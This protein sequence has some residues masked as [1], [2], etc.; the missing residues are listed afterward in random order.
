MEHLFKT[1]L[2]TGGQTRAFDVTFADEL[3]VFTPLDGA[4][5]P[6]RIRREEDEWHPVDGADAALADACIEELERYLLRQ[7]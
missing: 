6:V 7:H 5:A 2:P 3:Y 4:G 1:E